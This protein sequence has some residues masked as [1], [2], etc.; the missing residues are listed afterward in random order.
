MNLIPVNAALARVFHYW[1]ELKR[2]STLMKD[3]DLYKPVS[4]EM[5]D[6]LE[7]LSVQGETVRFYVDQGDGSTTTLVGKIEDIYARDRADYLKLKNG[8]EI[9]LDRIIEYRPDKQAA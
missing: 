5:S 1:K 7:V 3:Q 4:C 9:R 2:S 8:V 6:E